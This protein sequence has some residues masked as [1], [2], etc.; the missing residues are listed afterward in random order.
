MRTDVCTRETAD[1]VITVWDGRR[2]L[3][4][5]VCTPCRMAALWQTHADA[6]RDAGQLAS[7]AGGRWLSLEDAGRAL[8]VCTDVVKRRLRLGRL[9]GRKD[10]IGGRWEVLVPDDPGQIR[11]TAESVEMPNLDG[12]GTQHDPDPWRLAPCPVT[13][14]ETTTTSPATEATRSPHPWAVPC[15]GHRLPTL[16][17][18]RH[19]LGRGPPQRDR[20]DHRGQLV[21]PKTGHQYPPTGPTRRDNRPRDQP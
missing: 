17:D 4:V 15:A 12:V 6:V 18:H 2:H 5:R 3:P 8:G 21:V 11:R 7:A 10:D 13:T 1:A 20:I 9:Y 19:E 14:G 16:S